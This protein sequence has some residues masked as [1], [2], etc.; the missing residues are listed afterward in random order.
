VTVKKHDEVLFAR[1]RA[2]EIAAP[3][4]ARRV[5]RELRDRDPRVELPMPA[6]P[7]EVVYA[8]PPWQMGNPDSAYAPEQHY[9]TEPVKTITTFQ[10]PAAENA[11]LFLWAVASLLPEA[12]QVIAAWG[13]TYNLGVHLQDE[14]LLGED[15]RDRPRCW[16]RNRHELP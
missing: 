10:V 12:L 8:D 7:F 15:K 14:P 9:S 13:F 4:A 2:G 6:G 3:L 11:V 5:R 16:L 1:V